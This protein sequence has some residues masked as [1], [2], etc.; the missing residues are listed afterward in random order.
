MGI[1]LLFFCLRFVA[2]LILV[3]L[4]LAEAACDFLATTAG[5]SYELD[6]LRDDHQIV[7]IRAFPFRCQDD[8]R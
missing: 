2:S 1:V 8:V 6:V 3:G 4:F 5:A 7:T